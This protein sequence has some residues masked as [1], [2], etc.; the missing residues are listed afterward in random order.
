M[1]EGKD[2]RVCSYTALCALQG[3]PAYSGKRSRY[4]EK[5]NSRK[6]PLGSAWAL[7]VLSGMCSW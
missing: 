5:G 1:E 7:G 3:L 4:K 2:R 6:K